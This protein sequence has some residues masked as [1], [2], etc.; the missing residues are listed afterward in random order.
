MADPLSSLIRP[1]VPAALPAF[2]TLAPPPPESVLAAELAARTSPGDVVID[3]HGRGGWVA[4]SGIGALRRVYELESSP[5]TRLLAEVVLRPRLLARLLAAPA[6]A[7]DTFAE[8]ASRSGTPI[9]ASTRSSV[10]SAQHRCFPVFSR[11]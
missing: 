8:K 7:F 11:R 2:E 10:V 4:R 6:C 1:H 5:L 9:R 3:L